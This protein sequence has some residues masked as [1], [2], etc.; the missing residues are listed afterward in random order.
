MFPE[1]VQVVS[2][3][4][5]TSDPG[6]RQSAATARHFSGT[7]ALVGLGLESGQAPAVEGQRYSPSNRFLN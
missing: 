3:T 7:I 1:W 5:L 2:G 4:Y 6:P